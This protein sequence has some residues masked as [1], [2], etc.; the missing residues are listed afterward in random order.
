MLSRRTAHAREA[1]ALFRA[2]TERRRAGRPTLDLTVSNPTCL[3]FPYDEEAILAALADRGSLRYEPEPFG[4]SHARAAAGATLGVPGSQVVLTASTS[5]AYSLLFKLLCD[6]GDAVL[7]PEPSYPLFEHLAQFES[8][9]VVPYRLLYDGAWHIDLDSIRDAVDPQTRAIVVVNPNNPTG[10]YAK[11]SELL[12]I[13]ELGLPVISDEV[14]AEYNLRDVPG[15][16]RSAIEVESKLTFALSGLSKLA[17]LPQMKAGWIAVTGD[18]PHMEESLSR[19][20]LLCDSYLSVGAPVQHALPQLIRASETTRH[21]IR[22]R[23]RANY[24]RAVTTL[25]NS[26][27]TVLDAEG[28]WS[29]VIRLPR[30]DTETSLALRLLGE[31]GV[32]VHPGH[33]FDFVDEPYFVVSLLAQEVEFARGIAALRKMVDDL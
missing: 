17:G 27:A 23:T 9:R 26:A 29:A 11:R 14:F 15:R 16:V 7:I 32:F 24:H 20:E 33:F 18:G 30:V 8:V 12:A 19:L 21:A 25:A 13:A 1:N 28:G 2:L 5:E 10:S 4:L 31:H 3:G 22:T 6:P